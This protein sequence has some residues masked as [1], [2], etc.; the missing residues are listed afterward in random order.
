[1]N[2]RK[3]V[4]LLAIRGS[5]AMAQAPA[6]CPP[7]GATVEPPIVLADDLCNAPPT[8]SYRL[9]EQAAPLSFKQKA[10]YFGQNKIFSGSAVFGAAFFAGIAQARNDPPQWPQGSQGFGYRF[11]TR[12]TQSLTKSTPSFF[13]GFMEDPRS[14]PPAQPMI[15]VGG[16]WRSD[17][18]TH[19]HIQQ[20]SFGGRLGRAL[21]SVVWTHYDSG[22]DHIA[23][24]RIG[25]AV[26][27]GLVGRAWTPDV[28]NSGAR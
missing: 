8:N 6:F 17:P 27:S 13:F 26:A 25:G 14:H 1:M 22:Q 16:V 5:S 10:A 28:S 4:V 23:F 19:D 15:L 20:R 9:Q 18:K 2:L 12:Y 24:S 3:L 7:A 11:G 21:L